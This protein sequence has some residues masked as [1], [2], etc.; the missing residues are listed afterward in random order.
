MLPPGGNNMTSSCTV[1][2]SFGQ[3]MHRKHSWS[4]NSDSG[5]SDALQRI[6]AIVQ[7][8]GVSLDD[9]GQVNS[10]ECE[11]SEHDQYVEDLRFNN[12]VREV[13]LNRFVYLFSAYEHFV[14][15]PSQVSDN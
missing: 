3:L 15:Q 6:V 9:S 8:T 5:M 7:R 12:A 13:F 4:H 11:L 14:I 2:G 1:P 10:T